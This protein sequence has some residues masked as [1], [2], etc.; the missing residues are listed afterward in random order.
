MSWLNTEE[1]F[2]LIDLI[3][4]SNDSYE[5]RFKRVLATPLAGMFGQFHIRDSEAREC[6]IA[7]FSRREDLSGLSKDCTELIAYT[8]KIRER[9]QELRAFFDLI[10]ED[11]AGIR[12]RAVSRAQEYLPKGVT[13]DGLK[14]FFIPMPYNANADHRGVYFDPLFAFDMGL[15]A[16]EEVMAHEAHHVARNSITR[17]RLEFDNT[18]LDQLVYRFVSIECEGIANLVS[19]V[20]RIPSMKRV[21]L[22]RTKMMGEFEK[23][24]ELLQEV[25]LNLSFKNISD[26]EARSIME[27][28]WFSVGS[29]A[30]VGMRMA[31]EIENE[32]GKDRLIETVGDTVGFLKS[33]QEVA[34]KKTY[35]LLE[36]ETFIKLGQ[37]LEA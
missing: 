33:Y 25:F 34:L 31:L 21:A 27:R 30:P 8:D 4:S 14:V 18:P 24:L 26:D 36:D 7:A 22:L 1:I 3:D 16:I 6:L 15:G 20:S 2:A 23:H 19:D 13:F 37:L 17:E 35:Y 12:S 32:L 5:E 28:S 11:E 9:K 10:I 29:L